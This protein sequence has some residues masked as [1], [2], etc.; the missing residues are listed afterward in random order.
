MYLSFIGE[1]IRRDRTEV[2]AAGTEHI[3]DIPVY[4]GEKILSVTLGADESC[5]ASASYH[6][7]S[8]AAMQIF[9]DHVIQ[10]THNSMA[11]LP[12]G[13]KKVRDGF[14]RFD[15]YRANTGVSVYGNVSI[16]GR[17]N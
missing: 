14:I 1:T 6:Q 13:D 15:F 17:G 4:S 3:I 2:V 12:L 9:C 11:L 10:P 7:G 16:E 5:V 8:E